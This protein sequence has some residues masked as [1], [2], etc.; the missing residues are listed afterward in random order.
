MVSIIFVKV[1]SLKYHYFYWAAVQANLL[2]LG[3]VHLC[4]A[5]ASLGPLQLWLLCYVIVDLFGY[6]SNSESLPASFKYVASLLMLDF[7]TT[8]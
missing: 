8:L 7:V 6:W 3:K 4:I 2:P 5:L 1:Y